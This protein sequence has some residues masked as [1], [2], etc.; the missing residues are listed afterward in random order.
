MRTPKQSAIDT[1]LADMPDAQTRTLARVLHERH[2]KLFATV[3]TAR[4]AVRYAR[5]AFGEKA[6]KDSSSKQHFREHG[7]AGETLRMPT[8]DARPWEDYFIRGQQRILVLSDI[9]VPYHDQAAIESAI[10]YG[11]EYDPSI[12]LINGDLIDFHH[13][14]RFEKDPE[15]RDMLSEIDMA[16]RM[17][18]WIRQEFPAA[19]IVYKLGNHDERWDRYLAA[20]APVLYMLKMTRL[21]GVIEHVW[22]EQCEDKKTLRQRN[23]DIVG[24]QRPILA[25]KLPILH[26]HELPCGM[27]SP[28]NPARGVY[29]RMG[30]TALVGHHHQT[31]THCECDYRHSE[32][33]CWSTGCLCELHPQYRRVNRWNHGFATVDTRKDGTFAVRDLRIANGSVR[34]S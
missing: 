4:S 2:P 16:V 15:K 24:D 8:S 21:P 19:K 22:Q 11:R 23:V 7:T 29:L 13:G 17:L 31:S 32:V 1:L 25:G 20:N 18:R 33:V 6:R 10:D 14:S 27:V 5:G 12:V 9:H 30:H 28:V 34:P 26:G 3:E